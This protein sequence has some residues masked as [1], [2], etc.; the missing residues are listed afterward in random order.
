LILST[1][2]T[3]LIAQERKIIVMVSVDSLASIIREISIDNVEVVT[4]I[5]EGAEPHSY[6]VSPEVMEKARNADLF[7]FTGHLVFEE[8]LNELLPQIPALQI[9]SEN[10]FGNYKLR[11]LKLPDGRRNLHAYWLHP[12]N[13]L[14]IAKAFVDK[15]SEIDPINSEKYYEKLSV[16][17][18]RVENVKQYI[19]K[20]IEFYGMKDVGIVIT[21]PGEQYIADTLDLK[22]IGMLSKGEGVFASGAELSEIKSKLESREAKIMVASDV[23]RMLNVGK[24]IEKLCKETETPIAYVRLIGVK[25]LSYTDLLTYN[26]GVIVGAY[27]NSMEKASEQG[28]NIEFP[29]TIYMFLASLAMIVIIESY[30]LYVKSKYR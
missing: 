22:V 26:V 15:L 8:K 28:F 10:Y 19:S 27:S 17:E 25:E 13:A 1:I 5:P 7:V 23:S 6:Q 4:L 2:P 9:N 30:L 21:F 11:I 3:T 12:D 24:F 16:F 29:S 14:A 18:K 20:I